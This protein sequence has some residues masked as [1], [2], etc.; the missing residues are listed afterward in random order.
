MNS[1]VNIVSCNLSQFM[2]KS[3]DLHK[4]QDSG[5]N[6]EGQRAT[7]VKTD[8]QRTVGRMDGWMDGWTDKWMDGWMDWKGQLFS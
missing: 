7:N 2:L 5:F 3:N 8:R 1:M 6:Q 4:E